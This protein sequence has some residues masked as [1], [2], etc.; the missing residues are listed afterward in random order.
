M[1]QITIDLQNPKTSDE[2]MYR[3]LQR[4]GNIKM[5]TRLI[6]GSNVGR[7]TR[8]LRDRQGLIGVL[9]QTLVKEWKEIICKDMEEDEDTDKGEEDEEN[10]ETDPNSEE[11][12][13]NND[14]SSVNLAPP[15]KHPKSHS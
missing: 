11:Y 10:I 5:S 3:L 2:E 14:D 1:R 6:M 12:T 15:P 13:R 9:A 8:Y 4:L 7:V